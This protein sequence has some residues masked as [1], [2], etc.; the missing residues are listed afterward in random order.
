MIGK[1][2]KVKGTYICTDDKF[3]TPKVLLHDVYLNGVWFRQHTWV[4][5]NFKAKEGDIIEGTAM[6][7]EYLGLEGDKQ[8]TKRGLKFLRRKK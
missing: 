4:D 2:V 6:L 7:C 5:A 3:A 1:K 8:V